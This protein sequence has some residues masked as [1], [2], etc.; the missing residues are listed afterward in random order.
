VLLDFFGEHV[1]V[2]RKLRGREQPVPRKPVEKTWGY[3]MAV[4][5]AQEMNSL[6]FG[7]PELLG[8]E[9]DGV[10]DEDQFGRWFGRRQ[11]VVQ[12]ANPCRLAVIEKSEIPGREVRSRVPCRICHDDVNGEEAFALSG[13]RAAK[14]RQWLLRNSRISQR[15]SL[16]D[17]PA[18]PNNHHACEKNCAPRVEPIHHD[19]TCSGD[20]RRA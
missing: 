20:S 4:I 15:R 16:T 8:R 10:E 17:C 2:A 18:S 14:G 12:G 11:R 1:S 7:L 19:S 6:A 5:P 3:E 13:T 9:I